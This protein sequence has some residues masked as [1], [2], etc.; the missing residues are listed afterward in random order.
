MK[1]VLCYGDSNTFG[2]IPG[3]GMRYPED[4]RW[5][6]AMA[7]ILGDGYCVIE[8][9]C[10]G[11]TTMYDDPNEEWKNGLTHLKPCLNSHKPIDIL[12]IML[13]SNDLKRF[14]HASAEEIARGA[15]VLAQTAKDFL[16]E[17]QGY[18][19][20]IILVAP[21]KVGEV[22]LGIPFGIGFDADSLTRSE[23]FAEEYRK[24]AEAGGFRFFNAASVAEPSPKDGLHMEPESHRALAEAMAKEVLAIGGET[25]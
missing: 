18:A 7:G 19:P 4:V 3:N 23:Q 9:G 10:N 25:C 12:I 21:P 17:K 2:F 11:R 15:G 24:V 13:G 1:T 20:E 5:P 8:E 14:F 22:I 16:T 6:G